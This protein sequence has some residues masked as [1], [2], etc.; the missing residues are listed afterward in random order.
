MPPAIPTMTG[1]SSNS[2]ILCASFNQDNSG[3]AISTKDG[4]KIFDPNTGRL[5]YERPVG[6]FIIVEMLYSSSLLAIIG[7]GEQVFLL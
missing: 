4:F 7:A 5:C 3:F 6:A 2:S 1:Q